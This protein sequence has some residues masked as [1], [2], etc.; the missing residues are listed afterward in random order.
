MPHD[1]PPRAW[2]VAVLSGISVLISLA[3]RP[4]LVRAGVSDVY[5]LSLVVATTAAFFWTAKKRPKSRL[6]WLLMGCG[7]SFWAVNQSFWV[8]FE[9]ILHRDVPEPFVGDIILFMHLVPCMAA[10]ALRPHLARRGN[11][12]SMDTINFFMLLLWWV[13]LYAFLIFPDEFV[14]YNGAAYSPRFDLLYLIECLVL[15]LCLG[16]ASASA[17]LSWRQIYSNLLVGFALYTLGSDGINAAISR[18]VYSSGSLYDLPLVIATAWL[19]ATALHGAKLPLDSEE[20][21]TRTG[22]WGRL[23]PRVV[24]AAILSLPLLGLWTIFVDHEVERLRDFR[25]LVTLV[26]TMVLGLFVFLKQFLLDRELI[27]LLDDSQRSYENLQRLQ[28]QLVQKE[29]LASLGQ[30]VAGA[31]HEINNPLTAIL[32]YSELLATSPGF[33]PAQSSMAEKIGQQARRTRDLVADL[34]SFAQQSP[35]AKASIDVAAL[36]RRALQMQEVSLRGKKIRVETNFPASL[37]RIR[38]NNNQLLQTFLH[39]TDNAVDALEEVGGGVLMVS[40]TAESQQVVVQFADSGPGIKEPQ[41]VFDPFYTTKPV[42]KG[43]GLGLSASYGV[44]QDHG[45][46]ISCQNKPE[47]GAVFTVRFPVEQAAASAAQG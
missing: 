43:T 41:R 38:G 22:R 36:L 5:L 25:I 3:L 29:K 39:I 28:T 44:I 20:L 19:L 6:F 35:S 10:V 9:V 32:G 31:A 17:T 15:L 18:G 2:L 4:S 47:G 30:L 46:M 33:S 11:S 14:V 1:L 34:L 21:P 37:P 12:L 8:Y 13:F 27:G 24:M 45:G 42:G 7:M 23:S 16:L 26:A 40:A